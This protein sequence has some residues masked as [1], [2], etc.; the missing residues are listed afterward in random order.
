MTWT[1]EK[2]RLGKEIIYMLYDQGMIRTW[3]RDKPEGWVMVS[4]L[5]TPFYI[6][7]RPLS[8]YSNSREILRRV[9]IALGR[10]IRQEA[11]HIN[12]LVGVAAAGV[13]IAIAITMQ[14]GI[15]SCYTRKLEGVKT[16]EDFE[17]R[18]RD[19]GEHSLMEGEIEDGDVIAI[20][21]DLVTRFD[22]KILALEQVR[23][24]V[25]RREK[26]TGKKVNVTCKDV[27]VLVDREQGAFERARSLGMNLYSLIPF[28]SKGIHWLKK[29]ITSIEY[30][31][32]LDYLNDDLKYQDKKIQSRLIDLALRKK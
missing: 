25:K 21:D 30:E 17:S 15:P 24:E 11:P 1:E 4:G 18:I 19:Y 7:L 2:E 16:I 22:S 23:Y 8:S 14:E 12:K 3:Y 29:R 28:K 27:V 20:V 31:I 13:P 26:E 10:M 32:M 9:G 6:H 5:W